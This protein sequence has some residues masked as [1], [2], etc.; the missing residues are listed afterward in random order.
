MSQARRPTNDALGALASLCRLGRSLGIHVV[1]ATQRPDAGVLPGQIKANIPATVAFKVREAL[2]SRIL[3]GEE[4][5]GAASLPPL[6]GRGIWQWQTQTQFQAPWLARAE[7]EAML[8][9]VYAPGAVPLRRVG[10]PPLPRPDGSAES[11]ASDDEAPPPD[12]TP[13]GDQRGRKAD[14]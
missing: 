2:N 4:N 12:E 13:H 10:F 14:G 11:A 1:G 3:L 6:P 5:A 7:A 9:R 8:A